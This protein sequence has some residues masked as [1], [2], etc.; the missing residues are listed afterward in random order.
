MEREEMIAKAIEYLH[1]EAPERKDYTIA[2]SVLRTLG[3]N[4]PVAKRL[5]GGRFVVGVV[6]SAELMPRIEGGPRNARI[7]VCSPNTDEEM[8]H[9]LGMLKKTVAET[10]PAGSSYDPSVKPQ[11]DEWRELRNAIGA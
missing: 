6:R 11:W 2:A 3:I 10:H 8:L 4:Q 9:L 7:I 5:N 1:A